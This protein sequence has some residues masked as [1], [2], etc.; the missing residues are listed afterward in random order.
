MTSTRGS[1]ILVAVGLL[2]AATGAV[3]TH[4]NNQPEYGEV[5][6]STALGTTTPPA[7]S[8]P[9][10]G[11]TRAQRR[12]TASGP[13][14]TVVPA[15]DRMPVRVWSGAIGADAQVVPVGVRADRSLVLP[16]AHQVGWWIGGAQPGERRGTVVLAGHVDDENGN[17]GALYDLSA[18]RRG[19]RLFVDTASGRTTYQV[20]AMRSFPRQ[21]LPA[22]L[23]DQTTT[24]RLVVLTCGG[25]FHP[26]RGY[27]DN[28]AAYAVPVG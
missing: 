18:L 26:G 2:L 22:D 11:S 24:H 13:R 21:R 7:V 15:A 5:P 1:S 4:S 27:S 17:Q 3:L 19:D 28:I 14:R 9:P 12:A 23:F 16:P 20:V 25:T 10:A 6:T 8:E